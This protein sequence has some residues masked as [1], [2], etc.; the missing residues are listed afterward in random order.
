MQP[1]GKVTNEDFDLVVN[2]GM[3]SIYLSASVILLYIK[4]RGQSGVFVQIASTASIRPRPGLTMVQCI[5]GRSLLR[6]EDY[7]CRIC[8]G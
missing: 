5:E 4:K 1:T 3:K 6:D 2:L 7:G 8:C